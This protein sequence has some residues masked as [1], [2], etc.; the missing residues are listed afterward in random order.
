MK[1]RFRENFTALKDGSRVLLE[2][3]SMIVGLQ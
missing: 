1:P 2:K 3:H